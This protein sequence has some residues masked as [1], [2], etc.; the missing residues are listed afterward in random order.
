MFVTPENN[1]RFLWGKVNAPIVAI[2]LTLLDSARALCEARGQYGE[3][4]ALFE[5]RY[6][7]SHLSVVQS[8]MKCEIPEY[9]F[10]DEQD[11]IAKLRQARE[12]G[13]RAVVGGAIILELAREVGI[14]CVPWLP[15]PEDV[16]KAF[17]QAQHIESVRRKEERE[18]T[19]F[20]S[21]AEHS[22]SGIV[23]TD[24]KNEISV[25]NPAAERIFGITA[26]EAMGRPVQEVIFGD[27][28]YGASD[29]EQIEEIV[30]LNQ[31][32]LV[33]S[34][35]PVAEEGRIIGTIFTFYEVRAIESMEERIRVASHTK[36]L[37]AKLTFDNIVGRSEVVQQIVSRALRFAAR[38]DTVLITGESGTGKE[39]SS[40]RVSTTPAPGATSPSCPSI[41]PPSRPACSRASFSA[42]P[43][44]PLQAPGGEARGVY[45]SLPTTGLSSWTR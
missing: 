31:K 20:R 10:Y 43:R 14:P 27:Q 36:G 39:V 4:I 24:E 26:H 25:F 34:R 28:S 38:E 29:Q 32:R 2:P 37:T 15:R 11:G 5:F 12:E 40:L 23:V 13:I 16:R 17:V 19:K 1:A 21:V 42:M 6:H 7:C 45:S 22:F 44:A 18:A 3:P 35:I 41:V 9:V 30:T 8:I 33:V